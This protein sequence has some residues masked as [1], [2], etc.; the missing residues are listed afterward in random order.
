MR[1]CFFDTKDNTLY[2]NSNILIDNTYLNT[3]ST[4]KEKMNYLTN[5]FKKTYEERINNICNLRYRD[6][7]LNELLDHPNCKI[8]E[9]TDM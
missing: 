5:E 9:F 6:Y 4:K 3:L 1:I 8:S 7:I 2:V